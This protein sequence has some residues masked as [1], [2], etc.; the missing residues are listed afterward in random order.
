[1][2]KGT[3]RASAPIMAPSATDEVTT[4]SGPMASIAAIVSAAWPGAG[5]VI[6]YSEVARATLIGDLSSQSRSSGAGF[7]VAGRRAAPVRRT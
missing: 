5:P 4:R 6:R 1:M 7:G 3:P 2:S